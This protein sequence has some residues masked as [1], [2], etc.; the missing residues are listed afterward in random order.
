MSKNI[1]LIID[2]RDPV[3]RA[4]S[5]FTQGSSKDPNVTEPA[6]V[7]KLVERSLRGTGGRGFD[8][9]PRHTKAVKNDT[10]CSYL[11]TQTYGI[12]LGLVGPVAG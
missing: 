12:E 3:T 11:G 7:A 4:F 1:K 5:D 2:V 10:S 6:P 9:G 8:H